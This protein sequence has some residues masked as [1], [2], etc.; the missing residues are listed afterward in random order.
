MDDGRSQLQHHDG[1]GREAAIRRAHG[2]SAA[3]ATPGPAPAAELAGDLDL[4]ASALHNGRA[5]VNPSAAHIVENSLKPTTHRQYRSKLAQLGASMRALVFRPPGLPEGVP[6]AV[7]AEPRPPHVNPTGAEAR[8][9]QLYWPNLDAIR[10]LEGDSLATKHS[11]PHIPKHSPLCLAL[12]V[13][14]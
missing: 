6:L 10:N 13:I 9:E 7:Q 14:K 12:I 5:T 2:P 1:G 3:S 4:A 8:G 11:F